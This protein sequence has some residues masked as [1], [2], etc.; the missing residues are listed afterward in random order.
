MRFRSIMTGDMLAALKARSILSDILDHEPACDTFF[1]EGVDH[2]LDNGDL[3]A[4]LFGARAHVI[5]GQMRP[6]DAA[7]RISGLLIGTDVR[8][9]LGRGRADVV[10]LV[11]APALCERYA[12]ALRRAG[13]ESLMIDGDTA[14]VAGAAAVMASLKVSAN[15]TDPLDFASHFAAGPLI[16]SLRGIRPAEI[17]AIGTA[18]MDFGIRLIEITLSSPEP[19]N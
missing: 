2:A 1:V 11:G 10:T 5:T 12:M 19:S 8:T 16:T 17:E 3:T 9:G 15:M 7:S 6:Q 14:F 4:E 13:R 18:L